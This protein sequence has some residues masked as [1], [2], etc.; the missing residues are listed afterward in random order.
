MGTAKVDGRNCAGRGKRQ[1]GGGGWGGVSRGGRERKGL[2]SGAVAR[3]GARAESSGKGQ[4]ALRVDVGQ[5]KKKRRAPSGQKE[6][7]SREGGGGGESVCA[8]RRRRA[9]GI[10]G[11]T[12]ASSRRRRGV[13]TPKRSE[14]RHCVGKDAVGDGQGRAVLGEERKGGGGAGVGVWDKEQP[15][16]GGRGREE[17][18]AVDA[19]DEERR[20][21]RARFDARARARGTIGA[22][23]APGQRR[24]SGGRIRRVEVGTEA[25]R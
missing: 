15:R 2:K 21:R 20:A 9:N 22:G 7:K 14:K 25:R 23:S 24:Q 5:R 12:K 1:E 17:R 6:T 16:G 8:W 19:W 13:S 3:A 11:V 10:R 18:A 4:R